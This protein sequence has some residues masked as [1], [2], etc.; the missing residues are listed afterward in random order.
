MFR[1]IKK[2]QCKE[3]RH[4]GGHVTQQ[5]PIACLSHINFLANSA[6]CFLLSVQPLTHGAHYLTQHSTHSEDFHSWLML[7]EF[8]IANETRVPS[9]R[10]GGLYSASHRPVLLR[11]LRTLKPQKPS[12]SQYQAPVF[13]DVFDRQGGPQHGPRGRDDRVIK[14]PVPATSVKPSFIFFHLSLRVSL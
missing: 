11:S 14:P 1:I 9:I 12:V 6:A 2:E 8:D 3:N 13:Q 7:A 4:L 10:R 5:A